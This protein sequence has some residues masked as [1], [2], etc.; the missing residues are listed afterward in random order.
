[1]PP[2]WDGITDESY[3]KA[4]EM[5][6][7]TGCENLLD[8]M[9]IY[10]KLDVFL[11][12]DFF[13]Q[14]RQ[15][16]IAHNGLEPLTFFGIPGMSWA[17]ALMT[18]TD[19]IQL[20]TDNDMY[21]FFEGGIRGGLTFVNKHFVESNETTELL[22]IDINNLYGW[23][24][25]EKLPYKDFECVYSGFDDLLNDC[26]ILDLDS[27]SYGYTFEVDIEIPIDLHNKLS[28][29]PV[30]AEHQCP[31]GSKVK[32][33]LLTHYP[34]YN[35]VVHWRLLQMYLQLGVKITKVHR[36]VKFSQDNIFKKY[37]DD[38]TQLRAQSNSDL[39][40]NY[41]K[42]LN[43]SLYGKSVENLKKRMNLRLCNSAKK[44][45][46][47][48]SKAGFRK[49]IKIDDDL[50]AVLLNKE[51]VCLD[52]PSY[53]GQTVLDLSKLRMYTLQYKELQKYRDNLK[54]TINIVAG[55]TDSFFLEIIDIKLDKLLKL[56]VKDKL[57]DT[58]NYCKTHPLY[59][60]EL[61]SVVGRFKDENKGKKY[62]E[63]IFLKPKCYSLLSDKESMKAKGISLKVTNLSH[64]SYRDCYTNNQSVSVN[65]FRIGT[66]N[67][68]LL[69]FDS[70][71]I[72]LSNTDD[73]RIWV[74]KNKSL[75]YGHCE[76]PI[77]HL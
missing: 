14:F 52:R 67:H 58:S 34:K 1:M 29:L 54:C 35:Y 72:A 7:I 50:I 12:A 15:R 64:Q 27:L 16:S 19:P 74:E 20:L 77:S 42:L 45:L 43:N 59:S 8:Y 36:A 2:K 69:S 22:Y 25:S 38:N 46:T 61:N 17:S 39:D 28:D 41:Y 5:W 23:T 62:S 31:P 44:L 32:K 24:L 73:K 47:Y 21:T 76:I 48:T 30:A 9:M 75:P 37:I 40:K 11:L 49:T 10:L 56:M 3:N 6:E 51:L 18:L 55:D 53:I 33:L 26:L 66:H 13:Q 71:K 63:W 68:Q 65:Q 4:L 60:D 70:S 57:L